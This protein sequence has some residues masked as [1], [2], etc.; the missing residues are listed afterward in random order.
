MEI[1]FVKSNCVRIG[2]RFKNVPPPIQV[3]VHSISWVNEINYLGVYFSSGKKLVCNWAPARRKFFAALNN[4]L[5]TIGSYPNIAVSLQ[6]FNYVCFPILSYGLCAFTL[7]KQE[8]SQISFAYNNF[9]HKLFKV[10]DSNNI[11]SC[12]FFC[13]IWSLS[14][15][16]DYLRI[17]FI[18]TTMKHDCFI[19]RNAPFSQEYSDICVLMKKY[20]IAFYDSPKTIKYKINNIYFANEL[21]SLNHV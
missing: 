5:F 18:L 21:S 7:T 2:D 11:A 20:D 14:T 4:L 16:Y 10:S 15:L 6:L 1:N 13:G 19:D 9:F 17:T 8:I 3:S 12:Q